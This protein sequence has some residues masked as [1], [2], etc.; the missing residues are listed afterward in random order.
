[1]ERGRVVFRFER[2][3]HRTDRKPSAPS[4]GAANTTRILIAKLSQA[5]PRLNAGSS[6]TYI[7]LI[8]NSAAVRLSAHIEVENRKPIPAESFARHGPKF[9]ESSWRGCAKL[10]PL[11]PQ[12]RLVPA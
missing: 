4:C 6:A 12:E 5:T 10:A 8:A 7:F 3:G 1:M 11:K 9:A 2:N